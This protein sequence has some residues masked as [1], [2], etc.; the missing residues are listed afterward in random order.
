M[1]DNILKSQ[2]ENSI[3]NDRVIEWV[4]HFDFHG[5]AYDSAPRVIEVQ[6]QDTPLRQR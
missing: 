1:W 3:A 4:S 6:L 5:D 2:L